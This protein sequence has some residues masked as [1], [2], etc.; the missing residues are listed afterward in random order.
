MSALPNN[1]PGTP[2]P[3]P[4]AA[5]ASPAAD[6]HGPGPRHL[7]AIHA[8]DNPTPTPAEG[9]AEDTAPD[10]EVEDGPS[11]TPRAVAWLRSAFTPESGLYADRQP[12]IAEILRRAKA[13]AQLSERGP[14]RA[15]ATA[16][17]YVAAANKAICD[18]WVWIVAHPSRLIM[19]SA[20]VVLAIA[21]PVTRHLLAVL[22]T[23]ITWVQ[24]ALD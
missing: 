5:D 7:Y 12:S 17:G 2:G 24:Q 4:S 8:S 13:G 14:L 21:F 19:V 3:Q 1:T 18:T 23:P 16:H 9:P 15:L 22:L 6:Q 11:A 20:L 10:T